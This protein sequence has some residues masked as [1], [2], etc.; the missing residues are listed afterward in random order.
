MKSTLTII[1]ALVAIA[2]YSQTKPRVILKKG[3]LSKAYLYIT[4]NYSFYIS[5]PKG[6]LAYMDADSCWH[7]TDTIGTLN[8]LVKSMTEQSKYHNER[9]KSIS[10]AMAKDYNRKLKATND[11]LRCFDIRTGGIID[12][13]QYYKALANYLKVTGN[14]IKTVKPKILKQSI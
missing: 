14:Y 6:N 12:R 11:V 10:D 3:D 8:V 2:G 7:I 5:G 13:K 1:L 9:V 4:S